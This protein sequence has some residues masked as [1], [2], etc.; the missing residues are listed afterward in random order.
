[1]EN[2]ITAQ[3]LLARFWLAL[4]TFKVVALFD[5]NESGRFSLYKFASEFSD[6]ICFPLIASLTYRLIWRKFRYHNI[7]IGLFTS[8]YK[9]LLQYY[10]RCR[11]VSQDRYLQ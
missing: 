1:A 11:R 3:S 4:L 9:D 5:F 2:E 7:G 6:I 10:C 8:I